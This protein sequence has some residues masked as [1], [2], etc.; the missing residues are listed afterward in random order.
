MIKSCDY[1]LW[2]YEYDYVF[3]KTLWEY[4]CKN[5]MI[6]INHYYVGAIFLGM[7]MKLCIIMWM[8]MTIKMNLLLHEM[9]VL[10]LKYMLWK[11]ICK[12]V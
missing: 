2:N 11:W 4:V 7:F 12:W 10:F 8:T 6:K 3:R 5:D 1:L 9:N